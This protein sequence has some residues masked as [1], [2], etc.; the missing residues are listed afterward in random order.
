MKVVCSYCQQPLGEKAPLTDSSL[1]H[2][3][4][5]ACREHFVR[6]WKGQK[7]GA[8]LD[9]YEEPI[10]VLS[11][12]E[13]RIVAANQPMADMLGKSEREFFGLLGGEAVECAHARQP[14]GCGGTVHCKTC[15]IRN[16]VESVLATGEA[17]DD[18]PATL[19]T[20]EGK[21]DFL[22]SAKMAPSGGVEVRILPLT[23]RAAADLAR[24]AAASSS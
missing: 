21:V 14:E 18:V 9:A 6:Q 20:G 3:M 13:L 8:Y 5:Q 1:S 10:L 4:C 17:R 19:L 23:E 22:V 11:A 15:A 16:T 24:E 7:L 12:D 2:G